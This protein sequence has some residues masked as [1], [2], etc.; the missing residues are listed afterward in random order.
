M[1]LHLKVEK[2]NDATGITSK[3]AL[4]QLSSGMKFGSSRVVRP[5]ALL[6]AA[7][8]EID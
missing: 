6:A 4:V 1:S 8:Q 3:G 2:S 7:P 5:L